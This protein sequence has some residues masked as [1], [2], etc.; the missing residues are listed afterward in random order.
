MDYKWWTEVNYLLA[1]SAIFQNEQTSSLS[2]RNTLFF[3]RT[4]CSHPSCCMSKTQNVCAC[5]LRMCMEKT[6][7]LL[8]VFIA[9]STLYLAGGEGFGF[10]GLGTAVTEK[11]HVLTSLK[12]VTEH[13]LYSRCNNLAFSGVSCG[14]AWW[15]T[16]GTGLL[17]FVIC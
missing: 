2:N 17:L 8:H 3:R 7:F 11:Q 14:S 13:T 10:K 9:Y 16:G 6:H 5:Q 12:T 15:E 1:M 4:L